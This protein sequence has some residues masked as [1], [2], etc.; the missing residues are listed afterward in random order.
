MPEVISLLS[1]PPASP[2]RQPATKPAPR[3]SAQILFG[4]DDFD[5]TGDIEFPIEQPAKRRKPSPITGLAND[6][7]YARIS[8]IPGLELSSEPD[9]PSP[10][11]VHSSTRHTGL[12][13][14]VEPEL[15]LSSE[16][17]L[18]PS[19]APAKPA[20]TRLGLFGVSEFDEIEFSSSAPPRSK[21]KSS[22]VVREVHVLSSDSI[23]TED[24]LLNPRAVQPSAPV[25]S[26]RVMK[27]LASSNTR[28]SEQAAVPQPAPTRIATTTSLKTTKPGWRQDAAVTDDIVVSSPP[29]AKSKKKPKVTGDAS[30]S[31][32]DKQAERA[33]T[34]EAREVAKE[35]EKQRKKDAKLEREK[36]RQRTKDMAEVNKS[37]ANKKETSK[38]MILEMPGSFEGTTA[39]N[40]VEEY[41]RQHEV[42]FSY[43]REE[44]NLL[45]GDKH[46]HGGKL[47]RWK[48][49]VEATYDEDEGQWVPLTKPR[50]ETI[51]HV[52]ILI[53]GSDFASIAIGSNNGDKP[54]AAPS[55]DL[56]K[57]NLDRH[58]AN[59]RLQHK[60]SRLIYLVQGFHGW[61][62][63]NEN[64]RN[65][66]Y[67]AAVRAQVG[68]E[69]ASDRPASSQPRKRKQAQS[70]RQ[71]LAVTADVAEDLQLY[72]QINHQPLVIHHT[73]SDAATA[74]QIL[75]FTQSLSS[76]PYR[77][78]ELEHNLKS[79][80][81]YMGAGSYKTGE[82]A[83]ETFCRMLEG[84]Q[85]V[86]P[87][88]AQSIASQWPSPRELVVAFRGSDNL[89]LQDVRKSTNKDG[90]YSDKRIGPVIS[91]RMFK[92]FLGRDSEA[93]DGM[94]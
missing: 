89:M 16:H 7:H 61:L 29:K 26:N 80:S 50:V 56:M 39:G 17:D 65:R 76:R 42:P 66:E 41:M 86:T 77:I 25:F 85:R 46:L 54:D 90:G 40:Q 18:P 32:V 60:D 74:S 9:L 57:R 48:R 68:H 10:I 55:L 88:I 33:A 49:K 37:K 87:S 6:R 24:D 44:V 47:F 31:A 53:D 59:L 13:S 15:D 14:A 35:A 5:S 1:S 69:A 20:T 19:S 63:R 30:T 72:L 75:S 94:S 51:D 43:L 21:G 34:K 36:E 78:A 11:L 93:T 45:D 4:S 71:L 84:Q 2:A 73:T 12:F 91:R 82:D 67:A 81:F 92:V 83:E 79:S 27:I 70:P 3:L 64:S 58:V 23:G 52:A 62:K 22:K 28:V 8:L 38:E